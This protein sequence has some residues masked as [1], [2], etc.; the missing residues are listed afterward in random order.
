MKV[1]TATLAASLGSPMF[2]YASKRLASLIVC[3][4]AL[5]LAP[6]CIS[7]TPLKT[8]THAETS[9]EAQRID[10][11]MAQL[12]LEEKVRLCFGGTEAGKS[13][14]GG[15]PR[16]GLP[17]MMASDGPRGVTATEGTAF[18][19]G[20][21]LAMSWDPDLFHRVGEVIGKEA[22]AAGISIVFAPAVNIERDPLEDAFSSTSQKTP[23]WRANSE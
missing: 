1:T 2:S 10:V 12:T 13:Q 7:Q 11:I 20:I 18:P 4:A 17:P 6:C 22:R 21:G 23:I 19:S 5:Q 8:Q 3:A 15:V 14:V 16:L 9:S